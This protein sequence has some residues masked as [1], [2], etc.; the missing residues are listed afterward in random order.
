MRWPAVKSINQGSTYWFWGLYLI[1]LSLVL[2]GADFARLV[3]C[4][5][6]APPEISQ[7]SPAYAWAVAP[8]EISQYGKIM[9]LL[10]LLI[11][12]II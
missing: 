2:I 11:Y 8:P 4:E 12:K 6:P 7:A 3:S 5:C 9:F 10:A 1:N